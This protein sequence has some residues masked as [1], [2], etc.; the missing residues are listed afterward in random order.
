MILSRRVT[1]EY[2]IGLHTGIHYIF[3]ETWKREKLRIQILWVFSPRATEDHASTTDDPV[4]LQPTPSTSQLTADLPIPTTRPTSSGDEHVPLTTAGDEQV[5]VTTPT[6]GVDE[7]VPLTTAGDERVPVTTTAEQVG[8]D[9]DPLKLMKNHFPPGNKFDFPVRQHKCKT[10]KFKLSWLD[11]FPWLV[12]SKVKNGGYC[13]TCVLFVTKPGGRGC[14]FGVLIQKPFTDFR[15]AL[16][17]KEGIL[18]NHETNAFHKLAVEAFA[19]RKHVEENPADRIDIQLEKLKQNRYSSNK[20]A[21][22]SIIEY[23]IYLGRQGLALRGHRDTSTAD[24]D[25][26]KGNLQELIQFRAKT[27]FMKSCPKY[28]MCF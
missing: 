19:Q 28:A 20:A 5:P 9:Q 3:Q 24:P 6:A 2:V 16:G 17:K 14:E 15:K 13:L 10:F 7:Q 11:D 18:P 23:I 12:Y 26:N 1:I 21:L 4:R 8:D 22:G 27:S 25:T